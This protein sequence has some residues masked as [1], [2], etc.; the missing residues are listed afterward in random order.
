V[1]PEHTRL[2]QESFRQ[3]EPISEKAASLFYS[4]LF[5]LDPTLRALFKSDMIAQGRALMTMLRVAVLGLDRLE[6]LVPVVQS[7]GQRHA[8][9]GVKAGDYATVGQ[10][11]LDTLEIGLGSEFTAEVRAAWTEVYT[12]LATTM[13]EAAEPASL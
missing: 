2:V 13:Q 1:N 10:A 9:Y 6:D 4:R 12:V 3:I 7:L 11:L 8:T 5:E